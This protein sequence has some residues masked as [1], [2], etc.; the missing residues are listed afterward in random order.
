MFWGSGVRVHGDLGE[1]HDGG[2]GEQ[3]EQWQEPKSDTSVQHEFFPFF[4]LTG[5]SA[6]SLY[7][8]FALRVTSS[9]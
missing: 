8:S 2:E 4:I 5:R 9:G 7:V 3:D 1:E 6:S